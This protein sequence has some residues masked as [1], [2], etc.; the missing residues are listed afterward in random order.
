MDNKRLHLLNTV[1]DPLT[2]EETINLITNNINSNQKTYQISLNASKVNLLFENPFLREIIEKAPLVNAD[3]FS[4]I[5]A[6]KFLGKFIPE[7]VAGIDL[8][9]NLIEV[10]EKNRWSI[11]Y[12]G[13]TED[14]VNSV[15]CIH[16]EKYQNLNIAGFRNGYFT[17]EEEPEIVAEINKSEAKLLFIALPSPAKELW[18]DKYKDSLNCQFI[19]G[20]GGS[21]D[22][23]SNKTKRAPVWMQKYGCEWLYRFIQEPKRMF[24]RYFIGNILFLQKIIIERI[25]DGI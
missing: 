14:I 9:E 12:F 13:A 6:A 5:L 8:F 20:V 4:I 24:R 23:I 15:Y 25:S 3:G 2:M 10:A 7:R 22:V 17:E 21:F 16:K 1:V 19:M 18:I 11:F